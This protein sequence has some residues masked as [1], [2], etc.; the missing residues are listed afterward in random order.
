M[1]SKSA[2]QS[3]ATL[4]YTRKARS[5][6]LERE[7]RDLVEKHAAHVLIE[8]EDKAKYESACLRLTVKKQHMK[9]ILSSRALTTMDVIKRERDQINSLETIR[10]EAFSQWQKSANSVCQCAKQCD[11]MRHHIVMNDERV[12]TLSE[13]QKKAVN[14]LARLKEDAEEEDREETHAL[15]QVHG[16]SRQTA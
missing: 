15:A 6:R 13:Q 5:R 9:D 7:L 1:S 2:V 8:L 11:D 3:Y 16:Q 12:Q 4:T 10:K 14:K